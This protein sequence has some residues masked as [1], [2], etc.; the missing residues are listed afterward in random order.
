LQLDNSL[1][2]E[3]ARAMTMADDGVLK[4]LAQVMFASNACRDARNWSGTGLTDIYAACLLDQLVSE[5]HRAQRCPTPPPVMLSELCM[6]LFCNLS[7]TLG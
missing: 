1:V 7:C 4:S 3:A 5:E 2:V 6:H